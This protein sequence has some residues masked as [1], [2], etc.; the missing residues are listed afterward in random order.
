MTM[1]AAGKTI[2]THF[3]LKTMNNVKNV[4][5]RIRSSFGCSVILSLYR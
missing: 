5:G 4:G 3:M 1:I 2:I